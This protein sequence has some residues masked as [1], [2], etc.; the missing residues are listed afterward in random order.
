[1]TSLEELS[2]DLTIHQVMLNSMDDQY[3]EGIEEERAE[4]RA[5]IAKLK[6]QINKAKQTQTAGIED[7]AEIQSDDDC[8]PA[9]KWK[10]M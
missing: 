4:M 8:D 9:G 6:H 2:D 1:M 7:D 3:Y 10:G 5:E